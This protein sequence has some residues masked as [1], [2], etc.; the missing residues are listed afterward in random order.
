MLK[1]VVT[2]MAASMAC[3]SE[4]EQSASLG[5]LDLETGTSRA[6]GTLNYPQERHVH[7]SRS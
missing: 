5:D 6:A 3:L 2:T 1:R 4:S 7:A